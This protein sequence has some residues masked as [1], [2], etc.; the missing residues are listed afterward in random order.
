MKA[1]VAT[2]RNICRLL[3]YFLFIFCLLSVFFW[4]SFDVFVSD[5]NLGL[6]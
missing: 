1:R 6:D 5:V 2:L 3:V 4:V